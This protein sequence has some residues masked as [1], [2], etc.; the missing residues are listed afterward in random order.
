MTELIAI[1]FS[2][3][4]VLNAILLTSSIPY[5]S[6]T[7][8]RQITFD[9]AYSMVWD[10]E[11]VWRGK[12]LG[13]IR[14]ANVKAKLYIVLSTMPIFKSSIIDKDYIEE[15]IEEAWAMMRDNLPNIKFDE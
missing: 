3:S 4:I 11:R 6:K 8:K 10:A 9:I 12:K 14:K 13:H 5:V 15:I 7:R 1:I 2:V